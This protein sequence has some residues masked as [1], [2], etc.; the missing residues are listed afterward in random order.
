MVK[1][2]ATPRLP[3]PASIDIQRRGALPGSRALSSLDALL[4]VGSADAS[5]CA[6]L[7]SALPAAT[8]WQQLL[9]R[10]TPEAGTLRSGELPGGSPT[11]AVLGFGARQHSAFERLQLAGK[12]W[13]AIG[14]HR[15]QR[16][17][18]VV[19]PK[20]PAAADWYQAFIAAAYAH[21]FAM[22]QFRSRPGPRW[23]LRQLTLYKAPTLPLERITATAEATNLV[24]WLTA[25]P[26]NVLNA[27]GYQQLLQQL[28]R[29]ERLDIRRYGEAELKRLGAG[30]FRAV[31][32]CNG[33]RDAAIVRLRYRGR[34]GGKAG[35]DVTLVGKGV[36]FDTG[37]IN[38]KPHRYM[39]DM[40]T[41]MSGSAVALATLVALSTLRA[42]VNA[43]AWLA[44]TEN[45]IG[46]MAYRPQEVV[47]AANGTTIQVIHSDA[48]G[49]MILADTLALA[50]RGK[51]AL[52]MDF[53]TLTGACVTALTERYSG[54]LSNQPELHA[55]LVA[56]GVASGERVWPFPLDA[57]F[58]SDIESKIADVKQCAI[59]G[60]GDHILATRFLKR[61]V[62]DAIPW[63]HVDLA[64]ASRTGGLAHV[65]TDITGFGARFALQFLLERQAF[66]GHRR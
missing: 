11:Y 2:L 38:L 32:R 46:P 4:V 41:D 10:E 26:P 30:A 53:A 25:L 50:A 62:P 18:I 37:G 60:M 9:Q 22:P 65:P 39:L 43:E 19:D 24:R 42:P 35:S 61:F 47:R 1:Q 14:A 64:A 5:A 20:L 66:K 59:E 63:V 45:N 44:I 16:V 21:G 29:R 17:G 23:R 31:T 52:L 8:R 15:P 48:E 56:A 57:D 27:R 3:A 36:V 54:V 34:R 49:R 28:A 7:L 33:A 58:D 55:P 40:H 6:S 12:C 51:P 13:Q